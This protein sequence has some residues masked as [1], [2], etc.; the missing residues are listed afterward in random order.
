MAIASTAD[1][2]LEVVVLEFLTLLEIINDVEFDESRAEVV[3]VATLVAP[4]SNCR[5]SFFLLLLVLLLLLSFVIGFAVDGDVV[6][7]PVRSKSMRHCFKSRIFRY[8]E[9]VYCDVHLGIRL[10]GLS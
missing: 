8:K 10:F 2:T 5:I 4:C 7:P 6:R 1:K 3:V 9:E